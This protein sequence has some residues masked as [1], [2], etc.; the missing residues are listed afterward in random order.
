MSEPFD[1]ERFALLAANLT[2][3]RPLVA[4]LETGSTNDDALAA[5]RE[6][7]EHGALFVTEEQR[8]GRGR[9]GSRWL[10]ERSEGLLFSI[11]L[12]PDVAVER[13]P[14][15]ALIAGLAVREVVSTLLVAAGSSERVLVK[16]PNDVVI[17]RSWL[18]KLA[19]ILVES[20]VRGSKLTAA[21]VGVGLNV[22]RLELPCE[23]ETQ[24]TSLA[25][26]GVSV[27]RE[28][29]L[30]D[31]LRAIEVR[32]AVLENENPETPLETLAEELSAFDALKGRKLHVENLLGCGAG[33][34][35]DGYLKVEDEAG[36]M[37]RIGSGHVR[38]LD[39]RER[40]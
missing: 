8:A 21:I 4:T 2:L 3:G 34:D 16:W 37:H 32:L 25:A 24:A 20:Q 1:A 14:A 15:L 5:A 18:A 28:R 36:M 31:I 35:G 30:V 22:G 6:G 33:I 27:E 10:A 23:F 12:R 39:S 9:R 17:A 11:V 19:G 40:A 7:V 26:L 38:V 29:L 13:A